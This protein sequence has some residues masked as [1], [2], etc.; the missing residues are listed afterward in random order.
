MKK[1]TNWIIAALTV[2][3]VIF[4]LT[5]RQKDWK[6]KEAQRKENI[7]KIKQDSLQKLSDSLYQRLVADT[8]SERQIKDLTKEIVD[9]KGI[10]P[11]TI[12]KIITKIKE[13]EK[14][15]DSV[16]IKQ[17]SIFIEDYYPKKEN[18]LIKYINKTSLTNTKGVSK[19]EF[20]KFQITGVIS[21][22]SDGLF[23][24]NLKTPEFIEVGG[25]EVQS[26]PKE[27]IKKD[28]WGYLFGAGYGQNINSKESFININSYIR[29]KKF[30]IGLEA[31]TQ[32]NLLGGIKVEF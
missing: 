23:I 19:F 3:I 1:T 10:K 9:L 8:L 5:S 17:D 14:S 18:Y 11:E 6:I 27:T 2:V 29:Y 7:V 20:N 4:W 30:Y 13:V 15:T 31:T 16:S 12:I 22:Q 28:N 21:E 24:F 26:L 32:G 25:I